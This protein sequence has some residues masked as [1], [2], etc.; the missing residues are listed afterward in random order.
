M[1]CKCYECYDVLRDEFEK[2]VA[3]QE[4]SEEPESHSEIQLREM[5]ERKFP[6]LK[7]GVSK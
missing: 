6:E 4:Q 1:K 5:M 3:I 7:D 2:L